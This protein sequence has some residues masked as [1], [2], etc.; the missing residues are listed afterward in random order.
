MYSSSALIKIK[1]MVEDFNTY[2]GTLPKSSKTVKDS[3]QSDN[4]TQ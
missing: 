3:V 4:Q 2:A 1:I